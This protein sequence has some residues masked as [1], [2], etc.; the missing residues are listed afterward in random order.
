M[1]K[2]TR[3]G[4]TRIRRVEVKALFGDVL[5]A[6][7]VYRAE[8]LLD[9]LWRVLQWFQGNRLQVQ[10]QLIEGFNRISPH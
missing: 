7:Y 9:L 2:D 10:Q 4:K 1:S 5:V 8:M 6:A 3:I